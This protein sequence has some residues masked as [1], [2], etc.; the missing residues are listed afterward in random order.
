[1]AGSEKIEMKSDRIVIIMVV[2]YMLGMA[3]ERTFREPSQINW[4]T[5]TAVPD[6][7]K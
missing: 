2:A 1:M 7:F 6:G 4:S 5:L 3:I